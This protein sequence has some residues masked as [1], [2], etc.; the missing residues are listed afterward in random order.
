[1][2]KAGKPIKNGLKAANLSRT[3]LIVKPS[4]LLAF[5][6]VVAGTAQAE[7]AFQFDCDW[8]GERIE[9]PPGFAPTLGWN[10]VEVIRFAPGM[11]Q[12]DS[13]SF[14]SYALVFLLEPGSDVSPEAIHKEVLTY[15]QG[16]ATAVMGGKGKTVDAKTFAVKLGEPKTAGEIT[17]MTATLDWVEPFA[18]QAPQTLNLEIRLWNHGE[19][20]AI[21]FAVSPQPAGH[22]IWTELRRIR[23]AFRFVDQS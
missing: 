5:L 1:M 16:L 9:L 22:A 6:F 15:Y 18:T 13:E 19:Q 21:F 23:E 10:G 2:N 3:S 12:P 11:F 14:F 8:R 4:L 20:P 17:E 7:P